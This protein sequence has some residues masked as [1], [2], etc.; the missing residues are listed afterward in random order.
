MVREGEKDEFVSPVHT[1][2]KIHS[3]EHTQATTRIHHRL[4]LASV[5]PKTNDRGFGFYHWQV[6]HAVCRGGEFT[7]FIFSHHSKQSKNDFI[8]FFFKKN[9]PNPLV[10][11]FY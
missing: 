1:V 3:Y 4:F 11:F 10:H 6:A 8:N 5:A 2:I 7:L 9:P